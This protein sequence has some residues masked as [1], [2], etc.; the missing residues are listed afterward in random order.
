M[1]DKSNVIKRSFI[2]E[3]NKF[4][5]IYGSISYF[6]E[7]KSYQPTQIISSNNPSQFFLEEKKTKDSIRLQLTKADETFSEIIDKKIHKFSIVQI[8]KNGAV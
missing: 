7:T 6:G 5:S 4:L 1:Y 8:E 2:T 3:L